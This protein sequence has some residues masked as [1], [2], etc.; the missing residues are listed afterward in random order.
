MLGKRI[1]FAA[2]VILI[3]AMG[4]TGCTAPA[5]APTGGGAGWRRTAGSLL[6]VDLGRRGGGAA[7]AL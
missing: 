6:L 2:T 3:L 4:L 1:L 7:I 5:A